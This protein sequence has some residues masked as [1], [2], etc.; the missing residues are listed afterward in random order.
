MNASANLTPEPPPGEPIQL[1]LVEDNVGDV[2]LI[3]EALRALRMRPVLHAVSDGEQAL[4]FLRR[5]GPYAQAPRP[6]LI[7]LDLNLPRKTGHQVL[8]EVKSDSALRQIPVV[9]L[10]TSE[11]HGDV[12]KAYDLHANCYVRKPITLPG[13]FAAVEAVVTFWSQWVTLPREASR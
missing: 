9:V 6:D 11:F 8:A 13:L 2:R 4:S 5:A 3:Q 1:L 12:L 7:L 10:T